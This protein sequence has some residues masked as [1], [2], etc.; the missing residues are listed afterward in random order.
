MQQE[1]FYHLNNT[2]PN[3]RPKPNDLGQLKKLRY[4]KEPLE[5]NIEKQDSA[6]F[7]LMIAKKF[8]IPQ[9]HEDYGTSESMN[10]NCIMDFKEFLAKQLLDYGE[11]L[12]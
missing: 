1:Y 4:E 2:K 6:V 10:E 9:T 8:T 5:T 11:K 3:N 7:I 12:I